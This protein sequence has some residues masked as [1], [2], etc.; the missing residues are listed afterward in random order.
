VISG[1]AISNE[2]N[3]LAEMNNFVPDIFLLTCVVPSYRKHLHR[4]SNQGDFLEVVAFSVIYFSKQPWYRCRYTTVLSF[5]ATE[6]SSPGIEL[7]TIIPSF[8]FVKFHSGLK[9]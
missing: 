3:R 7:R 8:D 2:S 4:E 5:R 1:I 9:E 6:P